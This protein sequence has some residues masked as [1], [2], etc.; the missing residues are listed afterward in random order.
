MPDTLRFSYF[1]TPDLPDIYPD[2]LNLGEKR[3]VAAGAQLSNIGDRLSHI[4]YIQE[5]ELALNII[6]SDGKERSCMF[7][8]KNM[9]YGEAHLYK[10]FPT[11]FRVIATMPTVL[12]GFSL[13]RARTLTDSCPEFRTALFNGQAQKIFS[14]TGELISLMIHSPEERVLHCL[15]DMAQSVPVKNGVKELHVSQQTIARMLGMHRVTV[16]N[17]LSLLKKSGHILYRRGRVA[18]LKTD[19]QEKTA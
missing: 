8:K 14:M 10:E 15:L 1:I 2:I 5:G 16:A 13:Q 11:L 19:G 18:L 4:Y 9:F 12:I 7:V 6:S 17:A 3:I